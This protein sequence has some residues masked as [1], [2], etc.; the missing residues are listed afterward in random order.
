MDL[1]SH[2]KIHPVVHVSQLKKHVPKDA[3]VDTDLSSMVTDPDRVLCPVS[4][5]ADRTVRR[6][7]K[8]IKQVLVQ[9]E[10]LPAH[11]R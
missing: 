8:V 7:A 1:P 4:I 5:L 6:G 11:V 3:M 2:S 9:W 10:A